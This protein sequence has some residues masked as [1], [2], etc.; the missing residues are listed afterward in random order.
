MII[1]PEKIPNIIQK[2][3]FALLNL[4]PGLK[5]IIKKLFIKYFL[6]NHSTGKD[7]TILSVHNNNFKT[8]DTFRNV[9]NFVLEKNTFNLHHTFEVNRL[10]L[11]LKEKNHKY[12]NLHTTKMNYPDLIISCYLYLLRRYP[13]Q[14]DIDLWTKRLVKGATVHSIL[15]ALKNS[16]EF[17][18]IGVYYI[19]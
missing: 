6:K 5:Q 8:T 17:Q 13:S 19:N 10:V 3:F 4:I 14:K 7:N 2:P 12:L 16:L 18:Q 11:A 1:N 15:N 9:L